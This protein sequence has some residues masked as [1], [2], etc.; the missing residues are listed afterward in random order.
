MRAVASTVGSSSLTAW[1]R[2]ASA[3]SFSKYFLYSVHVVAAMVRSSP[4]ASAGLRRF[5]ASEP[6]AEPRPR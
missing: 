1:K 5:A 3:G 4:R 2:R 6:P